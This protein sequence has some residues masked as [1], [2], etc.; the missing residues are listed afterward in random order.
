M[1]LVVA[2]DVAVA[3]LPLS[4]EEQAAEVTASEGLPK[5]SGEKSLM[6]GLIININITDHSTYYTPPTTLPHPPLLLF[7]PIFFSTSFLP[8]S[9]PLPV[10]I[11]LFHFNSAV[12]VEEEDVVEVE[13]AVVL[14]STINQSRSKTS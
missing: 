5:D 12:A 8:Y 9:Q 3:A 7:P 2:A 13:D 10:V 6:I 14:L 1:T 4:A 11:S